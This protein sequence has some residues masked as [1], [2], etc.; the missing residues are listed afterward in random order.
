MAHLTARESM[1]R[2]RMRVKEEQDVV[3]GYHCGC[4]Q[5]WQRRLRDMDIT[6][7]VVTLHFCLRF[8][9]YPVTD[10]LPTESEGMKNIMLVYSNRKLVAIYCEHFLFPSIEIKRVFFQ[11]II[12]RLK[13]L[14]CLLESTI[15]RVSRFLRATFF[16][17]KSGA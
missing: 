9:F 17:D 3:Y 11:N 7:H 2:K 10:C 16:M 13:S 4:L 1:R 6:L 12:P 14:K 15:Y 5:T 8:C